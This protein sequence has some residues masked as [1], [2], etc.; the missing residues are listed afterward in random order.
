MKCRACQFENRDGRRFCAECGASLDLPCA[1]C[2]FI[3]D[4]S[5]KFCGGCGASLGGV[6]AR[7]SNPAMARRAEMLP[8]GDR[9]QVTIMYADISG[10][11]RLSERLDAEDLHETVGKVLEAVDGAVESH[12]GTVHRHIGDEVMALFGTPIAHSDDSYRAVLA[13]F[14]SHKALA[15][16]SAELGQELAIHVGIASGTVVV[17]AQG[18]ADSGESAALEVTGTAANLGSRLNAIA[19]A[20][21]TVI[22]DEVY[23]A[24]EPRVL[25]ESLGELEVKGIEKPVTAWRTFGLRTEGTSVAGGPFVGRRTEIAQVEGVL[26]ACRD[27]R[28][29]QVIL[30]RG[31]A[32]IGKTR[33]VEELQSSA[34]RF[35]FT[36]HKG[37]VLDFGVSSGKD[38][39]GNLIG[40][41]LGV[42]AD[43]DAPAR[44]EAVTLAADNGLIDANQRPFL[45]DLL[46]VPQPPDLQALYDAM[47]NTARVDGRSALVGSLL[48]RASARQPR[49]LVVEDIH[50]ATVETLAYLARIAEAA[51]D[52]PAVLVMTTRI[53]GD[54]LDQSWRAAAGRAPLMTVDL[55]PLREDDALRLAGAITDAAGAFAK[56]CVARAEGS[57]LFLE[58]LLRSAEAGLN[59][60]LPGTI[61]SV[62]MARMDQLEDRD[63]AAL[64][65]ASVIGQRFS[66]G[67]LRALLEDS[68]Y[69]CAALARHYLVVPENEEFRFVHALI[70]DGVYGSLLRGQRRI[71]HSRAARWFSGRDAT[72]RAEHLERADDPDASAAYLEAARGQVADY[73][74][75]RASES[76]DRGIAIATEAEDLY[77]LYCLKGEIL[78]YLGA[79]NDSI[80]AYRD[81]LKH[82]DRAHQRCLAHIGLAAGMRIIDRYEEALSELDLAEAAVESGSMLERARIH[83]LR[84]NIYFPLGAIDDC[85]AQHERALKFAREAASAEQEAQALSGLG[86]AEYARGRMI[87]AKGL[88]SDCVALCR[89]HGLARA[90]VANLNMIGFSQMYC[91]EFTD[92]L[93][94]ALETVDLA[95]RIGHQRAEVLGRTLAYHVLFERG[96]VN[97][98]EA[99]IEACHRLAGLLGAGRFEAQNLVYRAKLLR[100]EGR[101]DEALAVCEQAV[102]LCCETGMGFVGPRALAEYA[103]NCADRVAQRKALDDGAAIL[104][105]GAVS[106]NHFHF[107]RDAMDAAIDGKAWTETEQYARALAEF[108]RDEPLPWCNFFI[109]RARALVSFGRGSGNADELLKLKK[110]AES[111]GMVFAIEAINAALGN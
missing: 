75:D 3:N 41:L 9:R 93:E 34:K 20:G 14:E 88:F 109:A 102:E 18:P 80:A 38:A 30:V 60:E 7:S 87:T 78:Q 67:A 23:R 94:H 17:A 44:K 22:S 84:G 71:L 96:D 33:L 69:S 51:Q 47:D 61:Q 54:P 95:Q 105:D 104:H 48:M 99:Q 43:G 89:E 107:Y 53:E 101:R 31:E 29:G 25:C 24:V 21:E 83:H 108:T 56:S 63:K 68:D 66:L 73:H 74:Y 8:T 27:N 81:A 28:V 77:R 110:L 49:F 103:R 32:G 106:H 39:I 46:N 92:A 91:L 19:N 57:P 59:R 10:Y 97:G 45:N 70:R 100:L 64:Q 98:A 37:L 5:E 12:G 62:V 15:G 1:A 2:G 58:Q 90:E 42:P 111:T 86:D 55:G 85:R 35:G 76:V 36:C 79:I 82:A 13:A 26:T 16:L 65:A 11:T 52:C 50:W 6:T 40:G 4:P 72:L